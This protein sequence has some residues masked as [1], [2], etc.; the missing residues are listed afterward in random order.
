[1]PSVSIV[2]PTRDRPSR[3]R[4][5]LERVARQ[6]HPELELVLVRDGGPPLSAEVI[7]LLDRLEFPTQVLEHDDPPEGLAATRDRGIEA[8]RADS[9]ALLDDDDL[10]EPGHVA[11]LSAALDREPGLDVAYADAWVLNEESG[12]RRTLARDF[13]L[14]VFSRDSF[15]PPSAILARRS[16]FDRFG[17]FDTEIPYS[18]DWDWLLRVAR[19]QGH[20]LRVPGASVTIRIHK[21]GMSQIH[22]SDHATARRQSLDILSNRYGL[23]P[24][25]L[26]T[27][28][29]VAGD[30]CPEM[31]SSTR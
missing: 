29:E 14:E 9:I 26:K 21:G 4:D 12:E 28:W 7:D 2:L 19:G 1:M 23:P 31:N 11:R 16:A 22:N 3:L 13:D 25:E 8:S 10:W 18:E 15:I 24:I 6:T 30:L 20:I 17:L 27:F 5:A